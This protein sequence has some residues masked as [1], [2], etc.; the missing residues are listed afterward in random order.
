M[1][2]V[3]LATKILRVNTTAVA[4]TEQPTGD[5][6]E[7]I[8]TSASTNEKPWVLCTHDQHTANYVRIMMET[9]MNLPMGEDRAV[10]LITEL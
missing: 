8:E 2:I 3:G 4:E 9:G 10:L 6:I 1:P 5:L 7:G